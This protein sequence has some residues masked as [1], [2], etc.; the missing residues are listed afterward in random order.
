MDEYSPVNFIMEK[1]IVLRSS[2]VRKVFAI[3]NSFQVLMKL[4]TQMVASA[5]LVM[6]R[7]IR[8]INP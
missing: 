7:M 4:S 3:M 5:G 6:G 1:G 8:K 2:E